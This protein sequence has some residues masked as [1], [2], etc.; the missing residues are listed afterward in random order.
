VEK[1][2]VSDILKKEK[3][4]RKNFLAMF[5]AVAVFCGCA[6]TANFVNSDEQIKLPTINSLRTLSDMT[7]IAF[8][9]DVV[10][11]ANVEGYYLY[12]KGEGGEYK[13]VAKIKDRFTTH[14]VDTGLSPDTLYTYQL[15]TY[16]KSVLSGAGKETAV[17]TAPVINSVNFVQAVKG[18]PG[19]VKI[20][21]R[22]HN[23]YRVNGY[24]IE[25]NGLEGDKWEKVAEVKGRLSV[26]FIDSNLPENSYFRYRILAKTTDGI[27]SNPSEI[28]NGQTKALPPVV[29]NLTASTN[30]PKKIKLTW[31]GVNATDFSHYNV[32][33]DSTFGYKLLNTTKQTSYTDNVGNDGVEASYKVTAVDK[34]KQEGQRQTID[35]KGASLTKPATPVFVSITQVNNA[36]S[37]VWT[38]SDERVVRFKLLK[39]SKAGS[40]NVSV[41]SQ[42]FRDTGVQIGASYS[43]SV[44]SVDKFGIESEPSKQVSIDVK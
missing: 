29:A 28:V 16:H 5:V 30:L 8:E 40:Q 21:W 7:Q 25:R 24:V 41:K 42:S 14:Y 3:I 13:E 6:T 44:V 18:L 26:E 35:V 31:S 32:Y 37:L 4:M 22:P 12:R 27:V 10:N 43:Y 20:L 15:R 2:C 17:R 36:V 33:K 38:S 9:W 1:I 19:R 11:D 34:D 39:S 23:D